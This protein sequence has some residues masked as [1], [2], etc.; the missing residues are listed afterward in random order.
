M[1]ENA[2]VL[3]R[4]F[5]VSRETEAAL[6]RYAEL[7]RKWTKKINLVAPS[8]LPNIWSRHFLDSAQLFSLC[9]SNGHWVDIGS[10]GGFPGLVLAI[11]GRNAKEI[12]FTLIE[13]D[14]RKAAFL[15]T[16]IRELDLPASVICERIELVDPQHADVLTAR[17][18]ASLDRLLGFAEL[19]MQPD[20]SALFLKGAKADTEIED[21]LEHWS[22]HCEK[23][24]SITDANSSILRVERIQ[25]V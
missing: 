23:H 2:D 12:R 3:R 25:R 6:S 10:G 14:Q 7:L 11:L 15:R 13:A 19:H 18:L 9:D 4:Y 16:V 1:S 24:Q 22:F 5:D 21:A 20:G 17:A 8:S